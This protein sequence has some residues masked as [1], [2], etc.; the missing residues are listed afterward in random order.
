[1]GGF[2][3]GKT[4]GKRTTDAMRALDVRTLQR[5]QWLTPGRSFT[6][7]WLR[8]GAVAAAIDI[9]VHT[10]RVHLSYKRRDHGGDW[11]PMNYAVHI[12]W[13]P[14]HYGG[15]RAWW[16]CPAL[17]C[18]RRVAV[19]YG[20]DVFACRHCQRL[21]YP[22]QR[23]TPDYRAFRQADKLRDRLGWGPG[24]ANP[25]GDK[26]KGMHWRTFERMTAMH[27]ALARQSMAGTMRLFESSIGGAGRSK[28]GTRG[29]SE[30][31]TGE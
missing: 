5:S 19:L 16:L 6:W 29:G 23:E 3:S 11:H 22:S 4:G 26:P 15:Q 1:M 28:T 13:T 30:G 14:C 17:G 7:Q 20:G 18:G 10:D 31:K 8:R 9:T 24:I 21:A 25:P 27:A 12:E 2:G